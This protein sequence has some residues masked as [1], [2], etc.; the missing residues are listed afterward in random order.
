M[1][2]IKNRNG[3][4]IL[5]IFFSL[6]FMAGFVFADTPPPCGGSCTCGTT[7][8]EGTVK[9]SCRAGVNGNTCCA[10]TFLD[11]SCGGGTARCG[12]AICNGTES[13]STCSADCGSCP[14]PPPCV[15]N[16]SNKACG[17]SN[18]CGGVCLSGSC[19]GGLVC[20]GG[21]CVT[22]VACTDSDGGANPFLK[23]VVSEN[24]VQSTDYCNNNQYLVEYLCQETHKSW[25]TIDCYTSG[26]GQ[27]CYSGTC[28]CTP[29][30]TNK[31]CGSDGCG[32]SCGEPTKTCET[33]Y[34]GQCGVNL[35]N[36]CD[37]NILDCS[38]NCSRESTKKY[39]NPGNKLCEEKKVC[40]TCAKDYPGQCGKFDDGCGQKIDCTCTNQNCVNGKCLSDCTDSDKT[41]LSPSGKDYFVKGTTSDSYGT[42][43]D[44]CYASDNRIFEYYCD[45]TLGYSQGEWHN[46][47]NGC[48]DGAC[49]KCKPTKTCAKD[50]PGQCGVLLDDGCS[51]SLD[52]SKNCARGTYCDIAKEKCVDKPAVNCCVGIFGDARPGEEAK[53]NFFKIKGDC[54]GVC[55]WDPA[56]G[57]CHGSYAKWVANDMNDASPK[58]QSTKLIFTENYQVALAETSDFL[59]GQNCKSP[60]IFLTKHGTSEDCGPLFDY[61]TGCM[62]CLSGKCS[63]LKLYASSCSVLNNNDKVDKLANALQKQIVENGGN[64]K[65]EITGQMSVFN[66]CVP[67]WKTYTIDKNEIVTDVVKCDD[68]Y[69]YGD[70]YSYYYGADFGGCWGNKSEVA[71]FENISCKK[72]DGTIGKAMCCPTYDSSKRWSWKPLDSNNPSCPLSQDI[73]CNNINGQKCFNSDVGKK[74]LCKDGNSVKNVMCCDS[75]SLPFV[76]DSSWKVLDSNNSQC[77]MP[78]CSGVK[79]KNC[80]KSDIG[81]KALCADGNSTKTV[82]CCDTGKPEDS[83]IVFASGVSKWISVDSGA[84]KCPAVPD[85]LCNDLKG[86]NCPGQATGNQTKGSCMDGSSKKN[87]ICCNTGKPVISIDSGTVWPN[88]FWIWTIASKCP[89][90]PALL[91][92][93]FNNKPCESFPP[94]IEKKVSCKDG[95]T[96]KIVMCCKPGDSFVWTAVDSKKPQ[97]ANT[98]AYNGIFNNIAGVLK[99]I[100]DTLSNTV[101]VIS[102]AVAGVAA[103]AWWVIAKFILRK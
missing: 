40:K 30:C 21:R 57:I 9:Y 72:T 96:T 67:T 13:C 39:C 87:I 84:Q 52:C 93:D 42:N 83:G 25:T 75:G 18:G 43:T 73:L 74:T 101:V 91:C 55:S 35:D 8:C 53:C 15:P 2:H 46:C 60:R 12:D 68:L 14:P 19:S 63:S 76:A 58:C 85:L 20:E 28:K 86:K 80:Y 99:P 62:K 41:T 90:V 10:W 11:Y 59:A 4:I 44:L 29:N 24:G 49:N 34:K 45:A 48:N 7:K 81:K 70:K 27:G 61:A 66:K 6:L 88:T 5:F 98:T 1:N 56:D 77:S 3:F 94:P 82:M 26:S 37:Q 95:K 23:G 92:A 78:F 69:S 71:Q 102:S 17:A 36:G 64:I 79:D 32:G 38:N 103:G 54:V 50:Y 100:T 22:A 65:V 16:C 33:T 51:E 47:P 31:K 97:C 89:S